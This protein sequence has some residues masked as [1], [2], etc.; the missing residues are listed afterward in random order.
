MGKAWLAALAILLTASLATYQRLESAV[1]VLQQLGIDETLARDSV[2]ANFTG[3]LWGLPQTRPL[4]TVPSENRAST[5]LELARFAKAYTRSEKFQKAYLEYRERRRPSPPQPLGSQD[6]R[7]AKQKAALEKAIQET[8][9]NLAKVPAEIREQL[10]E[11]LA[12]LRQQ[13]KDLDSPDN[14]LNSR[15]MAAAMTAMGQEQQQRYAAELAQWE[16]D[17]H[18]TPDR[19]IREKLE[20]FLAETENIDFNARLVRRDDGIL[21]FA[22]PASEGMSKLR[23]M[24]FRAGPEPVEALRSFARKWLAELG[25]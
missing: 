14:P 10:Q 20:A 11:P 2:V 4:K 24:C 6:E 5:V 8:G 9:Q 25:S 17:N 1:N 21:K 12:H 18:L 16:A 22:D 19:M 7:K 13:L 3:T 15:E 23:K